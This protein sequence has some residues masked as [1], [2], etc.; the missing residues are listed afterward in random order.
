LLYL[1]I[2]KI[3]QMSGQG[4]SAAAPDL[5]MNPAGGAASTGAA[6]TTQPA[7]SLPLDARARDTSRTR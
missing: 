2:D 7:S 6:P 5:S 3:M 1:P 4:G